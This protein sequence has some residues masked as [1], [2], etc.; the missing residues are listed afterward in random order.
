MKDTLFF[1]SVPSEMPA[2]LSFR[3]LIDLPW[4]GSECQDPDC[5]PERYWLFV[6]RQLGQDEKCF[7]SSYPADCCGEGKSRDGQM[8]GL[9]RP[10]TYPSLI[11]CFL[12][13]EMVDRALPI[14]P[15]PYPPI[16]RPHLTFLLH[17]FLTP[18]SSQVSRMPVLRGFPQ[19]YE[20][21]QADKWNTQ[22][23]VYIISFTAFSSRSTRTK[24]SNSTT[25]LG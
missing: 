9:D 25:L 21:A 8:S 19:M 17:Q 15:G 11:L 1:L 24:L 4:H 16:G 20:I 12:Q 3:R 6:Q 7:K 14:L 22:S 10:R 13:P 5:R 23:F 2:C 18:S